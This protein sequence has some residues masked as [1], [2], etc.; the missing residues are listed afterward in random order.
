MYL[1]V[2]TYTSE[3]LYTVYHTLH[4][5]WTQA[6][7]MRER[8]RLRKVNEAF[9]ALKRRTCPNPNQRMPKVE[10][11]RTTIDYIESLEELLEADCVANG[12]PSKMKCASR[13]AMTS[14]NDAVTSSSPPTDHSDVTKYK[15]SPSLSL[16]N[17]YSLG[18]VQNDVNKSN[19][20][21]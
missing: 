20:V 11:L 9:E 4:N 8:R 15:V 19:V 2:Y 14:R 16:Y 18:A 7:T 13:G 6:A 5:I 12:T 21:V 10:I 3:Q 17:D 1:Q